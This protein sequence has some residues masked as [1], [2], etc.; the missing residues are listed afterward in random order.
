LLRSVHLFGGAFK[1]AATAAREQGIATEQ[2]GG[3]SV[4]RAHDIGHMPGRVARNVQHI[5]ARGAPGGVRTAPD[6]YERRRDHFGSRS[7]HLTLQ[8]T[9]QTTQATHVVHVMMR[10]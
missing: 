9:V 10:H 5:D 8:R 4:G 2:H 6:R 1:Q 3:R 7:V